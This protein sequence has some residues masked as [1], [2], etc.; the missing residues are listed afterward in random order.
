MVGDGAYICVFCEKIFER[1]GLEQNFELDCKIL[2][3]EF[4][5]PSKFPP[6]DRD[7]EAG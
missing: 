3:E 6:I 7:C 5:G 2:T 1:G 4:T